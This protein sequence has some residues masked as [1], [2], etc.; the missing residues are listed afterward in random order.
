MRATTKLINSIASPNMI[1]HDHTDRQDQLITLRNKLIG[2]QAVRN[3]DIVRA[4]ERDSKMMTLDAPRVS[5]A[6]RGSRCSPATLDA[7]DYYL[8]KAWAKT[9]RKAK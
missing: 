2:T 6:M 9:K 3:E 1:K 5:R 8:R 4:S 7:I